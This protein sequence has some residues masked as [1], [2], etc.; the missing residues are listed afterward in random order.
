[1]GWK[2]LTILPISL[3]S[4]TFAGCSREPDSKERQFGTKPSSPGVPVY[5]LVVHPLH[6]PAK[7][8]QAYQPLVDY[9]NGRLHGA[10][11]VLE[12]S[13]DYPTFEEKYR[14]RKPDFLLPN[15]W[16]TLQAMQAG[17]LVIAMAGEPRDF[18]GISEA[19]GDHGD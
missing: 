12:A 5:R 17:Y 1:M 13:R 2:V 8:M 9:L 6:N 4:G 10:R 3:L 16:Q 14:V 19:Q 11:L 7:L 15:P 18:R